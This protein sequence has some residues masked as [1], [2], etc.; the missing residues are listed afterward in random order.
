MK[1]VTASTGK[2]TLDI[3]KKDWE[4]IGKKAGWKVAQINPEDPNFASDPWGH[5]PDENDR[6]DA[7]GWEKDIKP[8][9]YTILDQIN[10]ESDNLT[11]SEEIKTLVSKIARLVESSGVVRQNFKPYV[12][13]KNF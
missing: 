3:S 9:L 5:L 1:L 11:A 10:E 4:A 13:K 2:Q 6:I 7:K 12:P 8:R